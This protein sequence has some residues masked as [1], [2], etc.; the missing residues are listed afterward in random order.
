M[1]LSTQ[2]SNTHTHTQKTQDYTRVHLLFDDGL[3]PTM[4]HMSLSNLV[5]F[6]AL[7]IDAVEGGPCS[8]ERAVAVVRS[9]V[10]VPASVVVSDQGVAPVD[11]HRPPADL[12]LR[13]LRA[14]TAV[15]PLVVGGSTG[16]GSPRWIICCLFRRYSVP[17]TRTL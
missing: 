4:A 2:K 10:L 17:P 14:L 15:V 9:E 1:H 13:A 6:V 3:C 12:A 5:S 16:G 7:S 11:V 8:C